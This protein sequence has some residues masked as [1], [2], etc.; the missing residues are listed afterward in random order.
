[1]G[2]THHYPESTPHSYSATVFRN[3]YRECSRTTF[4][5]NS[6]RDN[7]L[8]Y[9]PLTDQNDPHSFSDSLATITLSSTDLLQSLLE[10]EIPFSSDKQTR[11]YQLENISQNPTNYTITISRYSVSHT[12]LPY[13]PNLGNH[14]PHLPTMPIY[15]YTMDNCTHIH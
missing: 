5:F 3:T 13:L 15:N 6:L 4:P 8:L 11:W 10:N 1:M 9:S 2:Q 7:T 12:K 14:R